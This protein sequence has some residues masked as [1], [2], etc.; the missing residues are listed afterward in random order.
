MVGWL[1]RA[2]DPRGQSCQLLTLPDLVP[3]ALGPAQPIS[4]PR[5]PSRG[6]VSGV[7]FMGTPSSH[8]HPAL[9]LPRHLQGGAASTELDCL[10]LCE[11]QKHPQT[12]G[13]RGRL[14]GLLRH[15]HPITQLF[16]FP[17]KA[18]CF[19]PAECWAPARDRSQAGAEG[20]RQGRLPQTFRPQRADLPTALGSAF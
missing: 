11:T 12:P 3:S 13:D 15:P 6:S 9:G 17:P 14:K 5:S 19:K 2:P 8:P 20:A 10:G 7:S 18:G 16:L 4:P 1:G